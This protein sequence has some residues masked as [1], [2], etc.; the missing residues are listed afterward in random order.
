MICCKLTPGP[1]RIRKTAFRSRQNAVGRLNGFGAVDSRQS[2]MERTTMER[3]TKNRACGG[4]L[5][6]GGLVPSGRNRL[7]PPR[8]RL[9]WARLVGL[10]VKALTLFG[11]GTS[12][13][14]GLGKVNVNQCLRT[15]TTMA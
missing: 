7:E 14:S 3:T 11:S 13:H 4:A 15:T 2:M 6:G 10:E 1:L 5:I 8:A 9:E 12:A